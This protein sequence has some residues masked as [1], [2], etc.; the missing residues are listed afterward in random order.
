MDFVKFVKLNRWVIV[1]AILILT[2][3]IFILDMKKKGYSMEKFI[4]EA[5]W[6]R[7]LPENR[8]QCL[9]CPY[10]CVLLPGQRGQ[11]GVRENRGGKL[12]TLVYGRIVAYHIDPIEKKPFY[13]VLPASGSFS[14]ATAGCN[15]HCK[16]CQNWDISQ[17][18]PEELDFRLLLPEDIVNLAIKYKC[19]SIA[20]TYSEPI[21]F[22]ELVEDTAKL[23]KRK[24]LLNLMVTAG[25]INEEPLKELCK[26]IDAANV[27][28]K[29][30]TPEYYQNVVYGDLSTV[31]N[32]LKIMKE[33][34]VWVEITNLIV[35][36]LNDD[37]QTIRK[38]C[39][40]IK[41]NL[42]PDVPLH[43]SRFY[44]MYKLRNLPPT[45]VS[46]LEK[47]VNIAKEEG[48][49]YVYIG[50]VPG[51]PMENTYCPKCGHIL[52]KRRGYMILE[53]NIIDG[54]CKF[55][56]NPIPGIWKVE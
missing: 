41:E 44:P 34:G 50:N 9:L 48:L 47:A 18:K 35:P 24:G 36:T 39:K 42:G 40:W 38:M 21:V 30:F 31:L 22:Y 55:C 15:L 1:V 29:G 23:A 27:D 13:H 26:Y 16:F 51:H 52:I 6:Y 8:V 12:Y 28:L 3:G 37:P 46:T 5:K 49:N 2:S 19:K 54:K 14:I 33:N 20:Y 4:K 7:T 56:G 11:C 17:R 45:P 53:N 10:N 25:Y 43:F 32:T